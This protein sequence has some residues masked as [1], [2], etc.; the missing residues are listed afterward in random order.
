M[1]QYVYW[2]CTCIILGS[3]GMFRLGGEFNVLGYEIVVFF[4]KE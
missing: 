3:F 4:S 2:A 1:G